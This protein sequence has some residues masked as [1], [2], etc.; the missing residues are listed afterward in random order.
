MTV[1]GAT[2]KTISDHIMTYTSG[3]NCKISRLFSRYENE[4]VCEYW[5][6]APQ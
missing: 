3:K 1:Y 5:K 2:D 6:D 4:Y